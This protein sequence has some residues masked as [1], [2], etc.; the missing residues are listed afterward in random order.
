VNSL[1]EP[2]GAF[3]LGG[4]VAMVTGA[5]GGLGER[6]ARVLTAGGARVVGAARRR[7]R[8][9]ALAGALDGFVP[10]VCDMA[11]SADIDRLMSAALDACGRVDILVNNAGIGKPQPAERHDL[12]DFR[13]AIEV[14]LTGLFHLTSLAAEHMLGRGSGSVI[15][16]ASMLG[17]VASS[18]IND[19]AYAAS[20]GA[21]VQLTR[22]L[23]VQWAARGVRV[24]ALAP[25]WFHSE[26]TGA[27]FEDDRSMEYVRRNTPMR[28]PGEPHELD[29]AL[30]FLASGASSYMTGQTLVVDGGWT[31]R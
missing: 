2:L 30:L 22:E 6:F 11:V 28:R 29:G 5:S 20:K 31:A 12:G 1:L 24:N 7:D 15:N 23:G 8:L 19:A 17:L 3:S 9:E 25:G 14:N 21:V 10:I 18:P 26:M 16:V 4:K 13:A 27:M